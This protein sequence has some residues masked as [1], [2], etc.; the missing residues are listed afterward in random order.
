[1]CAMAAV[2]DPHVHIVDECVVPMFERTTSYELRRCHRLD[3]RSIVFAYCD[4]SRIVLGKIDVAEHFILTS[5][6]PVKSPP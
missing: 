3:L 6:S 1:M 5:G 4:V 2:K